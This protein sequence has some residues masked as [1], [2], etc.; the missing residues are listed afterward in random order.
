MSAEDRW[1][2]ELD[3]V[4]INGARAF[5]DQM[6]LIDTGTAYILTTPA[7]FQKVQTLILGA[8]LTSRLTLSTYSPSALKSVSFV[9]G[10]RE[11]MLHHKDFTLGQIKDK[12]GEHV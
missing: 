8:S 5:E 7:V 6:A 12:D 4:L 1:I 3:T 10:G 11:M 9:F 2:V